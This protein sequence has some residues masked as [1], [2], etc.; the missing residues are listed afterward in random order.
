M[1]VPIYDIGSKGLNCDV[2]ATQISPVEWT[3]LKNVAV[4]GDSLQL[5]PGH[6][7]LIVPTI[8]PYYLQEA[9]LWP[10]NYW[11]CAGLTKVHA[12]LG[13]FETDITRAAG[14][15]TATA[16][17]RWTGGS[18]NGIP[19]LN[20]GKDAPQVWDPI[21]LDQK[22]IDLPYWPSGAIAKT[23]RSFKGY[24]VALGPTK[25]S[26]Y[27]SRMVKWSD[28]AEPG[29]LPGSWDATDPTKDAGEVMLPGGTD[30][31][32]D[33]K[34]LGDVNIL[35]TETST[36]T[37]T[38]T[39]T[40][41]IFGFSRIFDL[42]GILS[43]D[44]VQS[45]RGKHFVVTQEDIIVH[46]GTSIESIAERRV[47]N[48]FFRNLNSNVYSITFTLLDRTNREIWVCFPA[49]GSGVC[50]L[51]LIWNWLYNTWTIRDLP[52]VRSGAASL[53]S[54]TFSLDLWE[55]GDAK[56]WNEEEL[57]TWETTPEASLKPETIVMSPSDTTGILQVDESTTFGSGVIAGCVEK[58]A[59]DFIGLDS[60][61]KPAADFQSFKMVLA[62]HPMF[63]AAYGTEVYIT[64]GSQPTP[65]SDIAWGEKKI[66]TVGLSDKT[67]HYISGKHYAIK[68]EWTTTCKL[69][70]YSL[71]VVPL[72]QL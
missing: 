36:W 1:L 60:D 51:A 57:E 30:A 26:V 50:N 32:V 38:L 54:P 20:S 41:A 66:F 19:F 10:Y 45:L 72:G 24:L 3:Q 40:D 11:I 31:L 21:S 12:I 15:Y 28:I 9:P 63:E 29:F 65:S 22:L 33:C 13:Q 39:G 62:V 7:L 23:L 47:R 70:G 53:S 61:G 43:Q 64:V 4:R 68:F 52:N 42:S 55:Y 25:S 8:A 37:Q 6:S 56:V 2:P 5:T 49:E 44:C 71:D 18:F 69:L 16:Y 35:Y 17:D 27:Y 58:D 34:P 46:N 59:C 48:W 14:D 67:D